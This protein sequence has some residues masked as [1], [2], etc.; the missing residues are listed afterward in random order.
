MNSSCSIWLCLLLSFA[1]TATAADQETLDNYYEIDTEKPLRDELHRIIDDH[2][3]IPYTKVG[4]VDAMKVLDATPGEVDK[5]I[6]IYSR[7]KED[8]SGYSEIWN[9]EHLWPNSYGLGTS[10]RAS[11]TDLHNLR[12]ADWN[13]NSSRGNKFFDNS[14]SSD[15]N[16]AKPGNEEAPETSRD[17][18]S[19]EPPDEIK[20]NVAR[21]VFYMDVR[22][23]GDVEK[24]PDLIITNDLSLVAINSPYFAKLRTLLQW[25]V[26]DPVDDAE[27]LRNDLIHTEYQGNRN[28]FVDYPEWVATIYEEDGLPGTSE[29]ILYN[30]TEGARSIASIRYITTG[31]NEPVKADT[32]AGY[33]FKQW[34]G[35]IT[36]EEA[37]QTLEMDTDKTI[38]A[39]YDHDTS[40]ND[41]DGLTAYEE[42][43]THKTDPE[44]ED[45][46]G[47]GFPDGELVGK[48]MD[49]TISYAPVMEIIKANPAIHDLF[50]ADSIQDT[51]FR[52]GGV[53][54]EKVGDSF[55]LNFTIEKSTDLKVWTEHEKHSVKMDAETGMQ[56]LR[57]RVGK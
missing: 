17:T 52:L 50:N 39:I 7:R 43:L 54:I 15:A 4:T 32:I 3:I 25:H 24:E 16:Y 26:D 11:Y 42:V 29:L 23:S 49:P 9:R 34:S 38:T 22:Y 33:T 31:G 46:T 8:A 2:T 30:E 53:I 41:K 40:D 14:D 1:V 10:S 13:V 37:E 47:D 51:H 36:G 12:P 27:I 21:A 18:D 45:T 28:P 44:K 55:Q 57:V 5:V 19:W 35:D 6:L 20:G 56:F 48:G